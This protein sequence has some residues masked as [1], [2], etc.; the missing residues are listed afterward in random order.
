MGWRDVLNSP[1]PAERFLQRCAAS[2][3]QRL[4][5]PTTITY[6][7]YLSGGI[8]N[9]NMRLLVMKAAASNNVQT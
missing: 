4:F 2:Q 1:C 7:L 5:A 6:W 3:Q 8:C 9:H